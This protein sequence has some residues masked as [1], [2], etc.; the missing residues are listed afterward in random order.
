[1]FERIEVSARKDHIILA[2]NG[3]EYEVLNNGSLDDLIIFH[4]LKQLKVS[5]LKYAYTIYQNECLYLR[6]INNTLE[7]VDQSIRFNLDNKNVLNNKDKYL[8]FNFLNSINLSIDLIDCYVKW[9]KKHEWY[10]DVSK[11]NTGMDLNAIFESEDLEDDVLK[12]RF[13]VLLNSS[14]LDRL[15][16][17][18]ALW[19]R[20][21]NIVYDLPNWYE[22]LYLTS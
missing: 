13:S 18:T 5:T 7:L 8:I 2:S 21:N 14:F 19:K 1:M 10:F 3:E 16:T 6:E 20:E 12:N 11:R 15:K 22:K 9:G 17:Y 4:L